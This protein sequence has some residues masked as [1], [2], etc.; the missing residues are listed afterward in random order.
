[1]QMLAI[2][3]VFLLLGFFSAVAG[4]VQLGSKK[5]Q[6][7]AKLR[8]AEQRLS[9]AHMSDLSVRTLAPLESYHRTGEA[10]RVASLGAALVGCMFVLLGAWSTP[11]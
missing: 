4:F 3:T 10:F 1:M 6:T 2:G 7:A 8:E 9:T 11:N 5:S